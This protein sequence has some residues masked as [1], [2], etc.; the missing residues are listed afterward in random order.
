MM[1]KEVVR[2]TED[3]RGEKG[4]VQKE[5]IDYAKDAD[6]REEIFRMY[7]QYDSKVESIILLRK[8]M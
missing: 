8:Q 4:L 1:D 7:L 6:S 5:D 2:I 3:N